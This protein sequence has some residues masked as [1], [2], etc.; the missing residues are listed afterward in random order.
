MKM[1]RPK[2]MPHERSG[3][4]Y[5]EEPGKYHCL[6]IEGAETVKFGDNVD[7][8]LTLKLSVLT[9]G[10]HKGM[11]YELKL[12]NPTF[13]TSEKGRE[14]ILRKQA[15]AV[16]AC[17]LATEAEFDRGDVNINAAD[18]A[19]RQVA[20]ELEMDDK[21]YLQLVWANIYHVDD[22]RAKS[23]PWNDAA[24]KLIPAAHRRK[25]ESFPAPKKKELAGATAAD[26]GIGDL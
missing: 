26:N 25:P 22:P 19:D 17:G 11:I 8:G 9:P 4:N 3:G 24:L 6:V 23:F 16:I 15:A 10:P 14:W 18:A 5:L 13:K 1:E 2:E 21:K 7:D 20:I 12:G